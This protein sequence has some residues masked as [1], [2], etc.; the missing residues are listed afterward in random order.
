MC[1]ELHEFFGRPPFFHIGCDEAYTAATCSSCAKHELTE[2]LKDHLSHF[3]QLFAE[4]N[5]RLL[6]WHD[7]FLDRQDPRFQS[8]Y[9]VSGNKELASLVGVLPKDM[10]F[11]DWEYCGCTPAQPLDF[12]WA[13]SKFFMDA[14]YDTLLCPWENLDNN[15][16]HGHYMARHHGFGILGT[17]W[18]VN[19][20]ARTLLI[21]F[22]GTAQGAW[23][24]LAI[25]KID[26]FGVI[27][28][29]NFAAA[30]RMVERDM[31]LTRYEEF[32]FLT[33]YQVEVDKIQN[34]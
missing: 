33:H 34:V 12:E 29:C 21:M 25:Q 18:H 19:K 11:C 3:H 31:Q 20:G 13:S 17:T 1:L 28:N 5:T 26:D 22:A 30:V 2:L 4:R 32:G 23:N 7:M 24:P 27:N 10:V 16:S 14:G 8:G 9:V 15:I 6:L